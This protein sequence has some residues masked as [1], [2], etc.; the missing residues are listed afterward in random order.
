MAKRRAPRGR[1]NFLPVPQVF[2][3]H[4]ACR[5]LIDAFDTPAYLVGS[6]LE[7]RDYRDV[8]VR[9]ILDDDAFDRLFPGVGA[10][11]QLSALWNLM[12]TSTSLY[13]AQATGLPIDFQI[14]RQ[15]HANAKYPGERQAL[16]IFPK[17][18]A[19]P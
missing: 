15:S 17:L 19:K 5:I 3:L 6:C 10:T 2:Q 9:L 8:D 13:L 12:C 1:A 16:G 7:R 4:M 14:Q 11:H 18:G